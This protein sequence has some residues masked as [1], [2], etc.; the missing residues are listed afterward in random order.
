ME[1]SS[2]D[3]IKWVISYDSGNIW[4]LFRIR[5]E[6]KQNCLCEF[7][8]LVQVYTYHINTC[9]CKDQYNNIKKVWQNNELS[10]MDDIKISQLVTRLKTWIPSSK[11]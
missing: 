1:N 11:I 6:Y 5:N 7:Y 3:T 8:V 4:F 2:I 9:T 10:T